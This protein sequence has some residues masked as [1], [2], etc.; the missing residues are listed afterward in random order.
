ML[1]L[2]HFDRKLFISTSQD[3]VKGKLKI[4]L[5]KFWLYTFENRNFVIDR[6]RED[7]S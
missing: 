4:E 7:A 6:Y 2:L 1:K 3:N 5:Q